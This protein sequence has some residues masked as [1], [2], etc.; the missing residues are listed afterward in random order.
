VSQK[1]AAAKLAKPAKSHK[2]GPATT[3]KKA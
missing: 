2:K 1:E 3:A